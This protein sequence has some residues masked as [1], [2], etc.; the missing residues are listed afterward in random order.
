MKCDMRYFILCL[1]A[2]FSGAIFHC[3]FIAISF[4][5]HYY[6]ILISLLFH[7]YI[8]SISFP[9]HCYFIV[10]LLLFHCCIISISFLFHC[11]FIDK[12]IRNKMGMVGDNIGWCF[13]SL[14]YISIYGRCGCAKHINS[15]KMGGNQKK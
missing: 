8:I 3:Y 12:K 2:L 7:S 10:I 11:Y 4:L 1:T 5:Y 14:L 13:Q 9:Y 15:N 6:F